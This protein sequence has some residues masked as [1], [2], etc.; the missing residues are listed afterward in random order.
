LSFNLKK[1]LL[2]FYLDTVFK[3]SDDLVSVDKATEQPNHNVSIIPATNATV[4]TTTTVTVIND[5]LTEPE[6]LNDLE[7]VEKPYTE[8]KISL[9]VPHNEISKP[10]PVN[11]SKDNF[12]DLLNCTT[13]KSNKKSLTKK[14][15]TLEFLDPK[16]VASYPEV[17]TNKKP[18]TK[19]SDTAQVTIIPDTLHTPIMDLDENSE[20]MIVSDTP[21]KNEFNFER[22]L[23]NIIIKSASRMEVVNTKALFENSIIKFDVSLDASALNKTHDHTL[24]QS[25]ANNETT[26][27]YENSEKSVHE[28]ST[29]SNETVNSENKSKSSIIFPSTIN[30]IDESMSKDT[31]ENKSNISNK[32]TFE[33]T[34]AI[35][36]TMPAKTS[37]EKFTKPNKPP[38]KKPHFDNQ[39]FMQSNNVMDS[40]PSNGVLYES[41]SNELDQTSAAGF[42]VPPKAQNIL[43]FSLA[44][45]P[46]LTNISVSEANKTNVSF[47]SSSKSN[48]ANVSKSP[49]SEPSKSENSIK[50]TDSELNKIDHLCEDLYTTYNKT[51]LDDS[52]SEFV[53][54]KLPQGS[55]SLANRQKETKGPKLE[56]V[57]SLLKPDIKEVIKKFAKLTNSNLAEDITDNTT[58]LIVDSGILYYIEN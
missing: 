27:L 16:S 24:P 52:T 7:S 10:K 3:K 29:T 37:P 23:E 50:L 47:S 25:K 22:D 36:N 8:T 28:K 11:I 34:I 40:L 4:I 32:E 1:I 38:L 5:S 20:S 19:P 14:I 33:T 49:E 2:I 31:S 6:L 43:G 26:I 17:E 39:S 51:V 18:E 35:E 44:G 9:V 13:S 54:A 48:K 53:K 42:N 58:H 46:S 30:D 12:N 15:P 45:D 21:I 55:L 56:F 41:Y 57:G